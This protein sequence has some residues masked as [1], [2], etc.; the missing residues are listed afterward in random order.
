MV[1]LGDQAGRGAGRTSAGDGERTRA[2]TV[3][4]LGAFLVDH[5]DVDDDRAH[6]E[7]DTEAEQD[8]DQHAERSPVVTPQLSHGMTPLA[9]DRIG[10]PK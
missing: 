4:Q 8:A 3:L 6:A 1:R 9:L 5:A 2:G 10:S 7:Q